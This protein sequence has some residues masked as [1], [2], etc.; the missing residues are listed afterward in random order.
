MSDPHATPVGD[1]RFSAEPAGW[2]QPLIP[3]AFR[4]ETTPRTSSSA[5]AKRLGETGTAVPS[6]CAKHETLNSSTCHRKAAHAS[7]ASGLP[8]AAVIPSIQA[9]KNG[10]IWRARSASFA[11][12][13]AARSARTANAWR[14]RGTCAN[15]S[16][17]I[18]FQK[19][20]GQQGVDL[21]FHARKRTAMHQGF[22]PA[23]EDEAY[24]FD[25]ASASPGKRW[26]ARSR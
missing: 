9:R 23:L 4:P 17:G 18:L 25:E 2:A 3:D 10:S 22:L 19:P 6:S 12:F 15:L 11:G 13:N 14:Y 16:N 21:L 7:S 20:G 1:G 5:V 8:E 26:R 24:A